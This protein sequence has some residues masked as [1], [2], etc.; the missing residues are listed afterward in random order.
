[1]IYIRADAND[2]IGIGHMMRCF[3][4]A[5]ALRRRGTEATFFVADRSSAK[6]AAEAGFGYVCLNTDYDRMDLEADRLLQHMQERNV[7][8]LLVDSYFVTEEYMNRIRELARLAYIDDVNR[9]IY[10]CDLLINYNIYSENLQYE[11]RY[12]AAGL[13]T[14]FALGLSYMPLREA[15]VGLAR[16]PHEGLRILVTTG[17]TDSLNVLGHFLDAFVSSGSADKAEVY[18]ICGRYNHNRDSLLA[19]YGSCE[20]IH[21]LEPQPDL[22]QLISTCDIAVTAGGTTV[23]EL[24]A[25]GIPSVMLTIADNQMMAA[26]EFSRRGIIPYAGDVRTDMDGTIANVLKEIAAYAASPERMQAQSEKMRT[27]VDGRGA[28]RI[29]MRLLAMK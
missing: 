2:K 25:G 14:E 21:L 16:T 19:E 7:D 4:I 27:V 3:S 10:P 20:R 17:A 23:Y 15:Y 1:M 22:T 6:M 12:R 29:A 26:R 28:D 24:C 11:E 13:H 5:A 18:A 9:F 8:H